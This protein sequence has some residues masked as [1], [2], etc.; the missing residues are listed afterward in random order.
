MNN[1]NLLYGN[2][3]DNDYQSDNSE[4]ES[5]HSF[6]EDDLN[7]N[8]NDYTVKINHILIST[9]NRNW[10]DSNTSAFSFPVKFN[11]SNTSLELRKEYSDLIDRRNVTLKKELFVGS[12]SLSIPI[13]IKNIISV[14]IEKIILPNRQTYLGNGNFNSTLNFN[15][16][17]VHI[18]EFSNTNGGSNEGLNSCFCAMSG[19][20]SF[21]SSLNYIE[22]SNLNETGKQFNMNPLNNINCLT[23]KLTDD[24]GNLLKYQNE[25]LSIKSIVENG[26]FIKVTTNEHFSRLN[27]LEGDILC[28]QNVKDSSNNNIELVSY[29][30]QKEGHKI[31]F[32]TSHTPVV[33]L[34]SLETLV[35]EF[36]ITKKGSYTNTFTP[37]SISYTSINT[38]TSGN[39]INKNLQL[40]LK[41]K[42]ECKEK[43][44]SF[45]NPQII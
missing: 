7:L 1:F 6:Q 44:F 4:N 38:I 20:S 31:Y 2:D 10:T 36:Y 24:Q 40:L 9:L 19:S 43:N 35:N 22:F 16:I 23:F 14:H 26:D 30:N 13:D 32:D 33:N 3:S 41:M 5:E 21:D 8:N 29:L 37:S 45:F 27:Y 28:F 25:T 15:T 34:H 42:I 39:I 18:E 17:L 12:T 11:T